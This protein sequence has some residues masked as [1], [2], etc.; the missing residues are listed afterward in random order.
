MLRSI[1][2]CYFLTFL[3]GSC[4]TETKTSIVPD[5]DNAGLKLPEG[6]SAL[7]YADTI[8]HARHIAINSNGDVLYSR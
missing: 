7:I 4:Q 8:G 2:S 1:L 5:V 6:F 3:M